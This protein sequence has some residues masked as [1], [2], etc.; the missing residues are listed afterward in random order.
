MTFSTYRCSRRLAS[1]EMRFCALLGDGKRGKI[2]AK[3]KEERE[4]DVRR[5]SSR[6]T[7]TK[8]R[9]SSA[10]ISFQNETDDGRLR[11]EKEFDLRREEAAPVA[12]VPWKHRGAAA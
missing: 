1:F 7:K 12:R 2:D 8:N 10:V 9:H 3:G 4:E 5:S 6:W 11:E